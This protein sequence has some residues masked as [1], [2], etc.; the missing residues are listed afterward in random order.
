MAAD[1]IQSGMDGLNGF[2]NE[3]LALI[4]ELLDLESL[5][6]CYD[7]CQSWRKCSLWESNYLPHVIKAYTEITHGTRQLPATLSGSEKTLRL[8]ELFKTSISALPVFAACGT[9]RDIAVVLHRLDKSWLSGCN[10]SYASLNTGDVHQMPLMCMAIDTESGSIV[11]GDSGGIVAFWNVSTGCCYSKSIF[12]S[13]GHRNVPRHIEIEGDLLV[14]TSTGGVVVVLKRD[15]SG[16]STPFIRM[17]EFFPNI[18]PTSIRI[19]GHICI[20]GEA[21]AV[22]FWDLSMFS[23]SGSPSLLGQDPPFASLLMTIDTSNPN[24]PLSESQVYSLFYRDSQLYLGLTGNRMQQIISQSK[25]SWTAIKELWESEEPPH[26][27]LALGPGSQGHSSGGSQSKLCPIGSDGDILVSWADSSIYRLASNTDEELVWEP[28]SD[29]LI[30]AALWPYRDCVGI[31]ARGEQVIC[32]VKRNEIEIFLGNGVPIGRIPC[33]L[34]DIS[35]VLIDPAFIALGTRE[36]G[37]CIY[38]FAPGHQI[39][40]LGQGPSSSVA[41]NSV[42]TPLLKRKHTYKRKY[43][44]AMGMDLENPLVVGTSISPNLSLRVP[45]NNTLRASSPRLALESKTNTKIP[46]PAP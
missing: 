10:T 6:K 38:Y 19:E 12:M 26:I 46:V 4:L 2:P 15:R 1:G 45:V 36:A 17:G 8:K 35:C 43:Q 20:V 42:Q 16:G 39:L 44:E 24:I 9:L 21:G 31:Y 23:K 5:F 37:L 3:V 33:N 30:P 13:S 7:V 14:M 34:G 29:C 32:R 22:S 27:R 41:T 11:T 28:R 18:R 25:K 40:A